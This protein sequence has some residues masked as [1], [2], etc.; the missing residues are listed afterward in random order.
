[1]PAVIVSDETMHRI[2]EAV[3]ARGTDFGGAKRAKL[4]LENF[5]NLVGRWLLAENEWAVTDGWPAV[6]RTLP[7]WPGPERNLLGYL[8]RR[9]PCPDAHLHRAIEF[10]LHQFNDRQIEARPLVRELIDV[11]HHL[12]RRIVAEIPGYAALPWGDWT[13]P[14]PHLATPG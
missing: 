7:L 12:A 9:R 1:M 5:G 11:H 8:W 13:A 10:Y 4:S 2:V 14:V 3:V 6:W